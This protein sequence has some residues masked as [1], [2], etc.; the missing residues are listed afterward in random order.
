MLEEDIAFLVVGESWRST[1]SGQAG[2]H[3]V[4]VVSPQEH[5]ARGLDLGG[6]FLEE[7]SGGGCHERGEPCGIMGAGVLGHASLE[8]VAIE[9]EA[10]SGTA[11]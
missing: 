11:A 7:T 8:A 1:G 3:G 4:V 10:I 5:Q 6:E 9:D 2:P